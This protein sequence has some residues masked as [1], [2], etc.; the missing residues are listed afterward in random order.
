[1]IEYPN[2]Y[3]YNQHNNTVGISGLA[4]TDSG[5][6]RYFQKYLIQRAMSLFEWTLP[7]AWSKE[8]FL[9]CLFCWGR[10]AVFNTDRFGV[11]PQYATLGGFDVFYRPTYA[12]ISN[13]LIRGIC[14]PRIGVQCELVNMQ[15]DYT[16]ILDLVQFHADMMALCA[17]T[18]GINIANSKLSYV[19]GAA[20]K[21]TADSFKT[22]YSKIMSGEPAVVVDKALFGD[23][24]NI[25]WEMFNQNVG[26]NY[27][28]GNLLDDLRKWEQRFYTAV[29]IPSANTEKKERLITDEVN[30]NNIETKT[31]CE[32]WMESFERS[33]ERVNAM[34]PGLGLSVRWKPCLNGGG[35]NAAV[36]GVPDTVPG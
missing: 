26:Q 24:G 5:L 19:F 33:C 29:G 3:G 7:E 32:M 1:M 35:S 13:P 22:M 4:V 21:T 28:A 12:T 27:I 11:I 25:R 30:A 6:S 8:Y 34:F 10:V 31:L 16:G 9:Y 18:A 20:N 17:Q 2:L 14:Q 36:A 23:D 15:A